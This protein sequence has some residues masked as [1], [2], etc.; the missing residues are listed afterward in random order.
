MS[1]SGKCYLHGNLSI[2][3]RFVHVKARSH[4]LPSFISEINNKIN[5]IAFECRVWRTNET[6]TPRNYHNFS[7]CTSSTLIS[8]VFSSSLLFFLL[9]SIFCCCFRSVVPVPR[10]RKIPKNTT[11][12]SEVTLIYC[13]S[14]QMTRNKRIKS[15]SFCWTK[16]E[17]LATSKQQQK[18]RT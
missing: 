2:H 13:S 14:A 9:E 15:L 12:H 8:Y 11:R 10:R 3:V 16:F 17:W 4:L 5:R 7:C 18:R 1:S 6:I